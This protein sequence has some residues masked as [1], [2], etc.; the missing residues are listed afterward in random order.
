MEQYHSYKQ[1]NYNFSSHT[2]NEN[3]DYFDK[4]LEKWVGE[5]LFSDQSEP[6]TRKMRAYLEDWGKLL[7]RGKDQRTLTCF[8]DKYGGLSLYDIYFD[9][10]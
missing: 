6:V 4:Q 5:T 1:L 3:D 9:K 7:M 10:I 8:L 2:W